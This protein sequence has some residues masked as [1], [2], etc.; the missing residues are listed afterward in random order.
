MQNSKKSI[1]Y[2]FS[3]LFIALCA[4]FAFLSFPLGTMAASAREV[5]ES[6]PEARTLAKATVAPTLSAVR[7]KRTTDYVS[8]PITLWG[9]ATGTKALMINGTLYIP[10]N[11]FAESV[12]A[13]VKYDTASKTLTVSA[14]GLYLTVSDGA[15]VTYVNDRPFFS[16][17][18][19]AVMSDGRTY[20]PISSVMKAFGLN[21]THTSRGVFVSGTFTPPMHA[22]RFYREDEVLWLSRI[23]SAESKGEPLLGQIAVGS[24]VMNR[25]A[26]K[27]YPNT[28]Y[29]V[30]F[31]RK[32]GVQFSP[33]L[34]GSIYGTPT[35][36][37]TLAAKICLEGVR[38]GDG[39]LFFLRPEA[40]S[41]L[42]IPTTRKFLFSIGNHDFYA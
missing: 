11:S 25:V 24:V 28:I 3:A 7:S 2:R 1:R 33:I 8:Y 29:S 19:S 10:M 17:Q 40:S 41:S 14:N 6:T 23:I 30:I 39:A 32:Y 27:D 12:G 5:G 35:Y 13:K 36:N 15:Y 20:V 42:W 38:V 26:S 4:L 9:K 18:N 31:D 21:Y 34:D 22:S 16:G 37:C